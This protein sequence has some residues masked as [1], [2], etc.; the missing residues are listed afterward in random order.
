MS[1]QS[2]QDAPTP[3]VPSDRPVP[4]SPSQQAVD[5]QSVAAAVVAASL[6]A[7]GRSASSADPGWPP[8]SSAQ[9]AAAPAQAT[10]T[11][12]P[13]QYVPTVRELKRRHQPLHLLRNAVRAN[14]M[15]AQDH[16]FTGE[17]ISPALWRLFAITEAHADPVDNLSTEPSALNGAP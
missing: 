10:Q 11:R 17:E 5:N 15:P 16:L 8:A 2:H 14:V 9:Q 4:A 1:M 7:A 6:R 3:L 13:Q 12:P